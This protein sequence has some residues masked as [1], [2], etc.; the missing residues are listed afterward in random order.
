MKW[1]LIYIVING[2]EPYVINAQGPRVTFDTMYECFNAREI[3][4]GSIGIG[5]GYFKPGQQAVCIEVP[6]NDK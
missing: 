2:G 1:M 4:S 3:L 5:S 6:P